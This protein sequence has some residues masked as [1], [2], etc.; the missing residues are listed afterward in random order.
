MTQSHVESE[1]L[2]EADAGSGRIELCFITSSMYK[3]EAV[4]E[5]LGIPIKLVEVEMEE[6]QGT[7]EEIAWNKLRRVSSMATES[8]CVLID[9]TSIHLDGLYGFPGPYGKAFLEMGME[10]VLRIVE[11]VGTGC[12][13][14]TI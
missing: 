7:E 2:G 6:I 13:Y 8:C 9:D 11:A 12:I 10:R 14:S 4:R 5:I 1:A 3:Y